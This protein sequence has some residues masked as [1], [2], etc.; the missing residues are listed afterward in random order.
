MNWWRMR[1]DEVVVSVVTGMF[2]YMEAEL[3]MADVNVLSLDAC[4]DCWQRCNAS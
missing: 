3:L 4:M 2:S 1:L